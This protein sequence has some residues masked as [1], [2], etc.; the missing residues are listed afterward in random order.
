MQHR[1]KLA[2]VS[3]MLLAAAQVYLGFLRQAP[4]SG[5]IFPVLYVL[6]LRGHTLARRVLYIWSTGLILIGI[7]S[8]KA[9]ARIMLPA[10]RVP[11]SGVIV[12]AA[13]A[14]MVTC[15]YAKRPKNS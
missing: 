2:A 15:F 9:A 11:L 8:L 13:L 4:L 12:C 5:F 6:I 14:I 3:D 1:K 10:D 7:G